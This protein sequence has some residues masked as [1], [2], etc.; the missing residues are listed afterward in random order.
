MKKILI[1]LIVIFTLIL[2][3]Q[4]FTLYQSVDTIIE[5]D[6]LPVEEKDYSEVIAE[7]DEDVLPIIN[8][9]KDQAIRDILNSIFDDV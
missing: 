8:D 6:P 4:W 3:Y 5:A 9:D 7:T 2:L 1:S